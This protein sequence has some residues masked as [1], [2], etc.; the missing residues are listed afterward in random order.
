M[1]HNKTLLAVACGALLASSCATAEQH[2]DYR[3]RGRVLKV[4][5]IYEVVRA[6]HPEEHCW[7]ERVQVRGGNDATPTIAGAVVGGVVGNQFGHGSG[8]AAA[9]AAGAL[10]GGAIGNDI[11][12]D[13]DPAY[14]VERRCETRDRVVERNEVVAYRVKYEYQGRVD[15]TRTRERPGKFIDLDV[16]VDVHPSHH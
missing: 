8:K 9:T 11:G 6:N 2:A 1:K 3:A 13:R 10:L 5:P 12:R 7:E 15:W 4:E 16:D 14:R